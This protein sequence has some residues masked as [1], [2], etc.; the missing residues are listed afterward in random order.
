MVKFIDPQADPAQGW[1]SRGHM[2]EVNSG[3]TVPEVIALLTNQ[4][5]GVS[6]G[7]LGT[8]S[9]GLWDGCYSG[10]HRGWKYREVLL[11]A[12]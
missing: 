6:K 1:A 5:S 9:D 10:L 7:L 4:G 2:L 3:A 8:H 11:L 12:S